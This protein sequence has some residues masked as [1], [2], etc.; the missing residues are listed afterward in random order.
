M[1]GGHARLWWRLSGCTLVPGG[2]P[3][4]AGESDCGGG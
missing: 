2:Q 1:P 3:V 4:R